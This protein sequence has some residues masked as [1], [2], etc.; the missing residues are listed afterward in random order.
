MVAVASQHSGSSI[1]DIRIAISALAAEQI[2]ILQNDRAEA[3]VL[4]S[5]ANN[6]QRTFQL[7]LHFL[8]DS[9]I[10]IKDYEV[11]AATSYW[12]YN[13]STRVL[14]RTTTISRRPHGG[15]SLEGKKG[16]VHTDSSLS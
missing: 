3:R 6:T 14:Q 1:F 5:A 15:F 4:M 12:Y 9:R 11:N 2:N 13:I 16:P 8:N 10:A 7:R